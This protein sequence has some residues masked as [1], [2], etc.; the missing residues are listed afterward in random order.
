MY[1]ATQNHSLLMMPKHEY[2]NAKQLQYLDDNWG[3][4]VGEN[5]SSR[6]SHSKKNTILYFV[7]AEYRCT[8]AVWFLLVA[9]LINK[10]VRSN[11]LTLVKVCPLPKH[12]KFQS[13]VE[14]CYWNVLRR[15]DSA[16]S[17]SDQM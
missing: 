2:L 13:R 12:G 14:S 8:V 6:L 11:V 3:R 16:E 10:T 5:S 7:I 9:Y 15:C 4:S 17:I 1:R